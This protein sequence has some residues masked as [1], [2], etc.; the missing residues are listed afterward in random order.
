MNLKAKR[1]IRTPYSEQYALFDLNRTD[2]NYDPLSVGKLDLHYTQHGIYGT[3]LF[4]AEASEHYAWDDVLREAELLLAEFQAPMGVS[5]EYAI[6][7]FSPT[8]KQYEVLSNIEEEETSYLA[9][10]DSDELAGEEI[11][12]EDEEYHSIW[13]GFASQAS[14]NEEDGEPEDDIDDEADDESGEDLAPRPSRRLGIH[15]QP[16]WVDN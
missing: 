2:E 1:L 9:S 16:E 13:P 4:W 10:L 6:E 3:L 11:D 7:L 15:G 5:G 8:L 14:L 12:G